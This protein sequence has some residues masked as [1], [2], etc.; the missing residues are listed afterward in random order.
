MKLLIASNNTHKIEEIKS[1]LNGRFEKIFSLSEMGVHCDPEENGTTFAE[2]ALIKA[3]EVSKQTNL[4][5]LADD[6]GLCV[7]AL[8]GAPGVFSAR[9][10]ATDGGHND[11]ANRQK[12]LKELHGTTDRSA[13][14]ECAVV[15]LYPDGKYV[16]SSGRVDGEILQEERGKNGFGYDSL[17]LATELGKTFAEADSEE[18]NKISHR[19]RALQALLKKL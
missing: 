1:I 2:N 16:S 19:G 15:L 6:T 5:V 4:P 17:F 7:D 3:R 13:H 11:A 12:L 9:Y 8:N 18:K 10:A 14:F